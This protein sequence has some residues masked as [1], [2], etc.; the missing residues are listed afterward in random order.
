ML[1]TLVN[2]DTQLLLLLNS[3]HSP[4][5]DAIMWQ[6]STKTL[7]I[8]FYAVLLFFMIWKHKK[9]WW[10]TILSIAIMILLSDQLADFIKDNV[11]RLRPTHNPAIANLVHILRDYRGGNFGFV[12]SHASN[13]FAIATFVSMFFAKRWLTISM[14]LWAALVCYSRVYL[15]VHYPGDVLCGAIVGAGV[16]I[17]IW[18]PAN[19]FFNKEKLS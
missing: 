18:L 15:G 13:S 14:F 9:Y 10:I 8:P 4:F 17:S 6:I 7:W 11:Q 19:Y 3:L 5:W 2:W 16:G 1:Q 12:S